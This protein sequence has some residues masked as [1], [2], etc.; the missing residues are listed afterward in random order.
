MPPLLALRA[1]VFVLVS[2][3]FSDPSWSKQHRSHAAIAEFK[4]QYPCPATGAPRGLCPGYV[5]DHVVPLC[6]G[7]PDAPANMQWQTVVDA[8]VKDRAGAGAMPT[9]TVNPRANP[10]LCAVQQCSE[11]TPS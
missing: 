4:C 9:T 8:K 7:G 2:A 6:A 1:L 11:L 10:R 3:I 5:I